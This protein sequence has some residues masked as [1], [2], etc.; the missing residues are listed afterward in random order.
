MQMSTRALFTMSNG[1][2][3]RICILFLNAC[4]TLISISAGVYTATLMSKNGLNTFPAI[5]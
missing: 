5:F 2:G 4:L 3:E 1:V